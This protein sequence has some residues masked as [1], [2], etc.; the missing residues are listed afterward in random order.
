MRRGSSKTSASGFA[1]I[2]VLLVLL[3]LLVLCA[4]FLLTARNADRASAELSDRVEARLLLD[5]AARHARVGLQT[6]HPALDSTPYFDTEEE[7]E[8]RSRFP[9]GFLQAA[10]PAGQMWQAQA[11]DLSG[12]IDLNSAPPQVFANL[13]G[14]STRLTAPL[15]PNS[16]ELPLSSVN[17]L[18][19]TGYVWIAGEWVRYGKLGESDLQQFLRGVNSVGTDWMGGPKP[20]STHGAGT[21]VLDQRA[22]AAPLWRTMGTDGAYR[23]FEE[24]EQLRDSA[25][26]ALAVAT[27]GAAGAQAYEGRVLAPLFDW[28]SVYVPVRSGSRWQYPVRVLSPVVGGQDGRLRVSSTRWLNPGA[29]VQID[30][31]TTRETALVVEVSGDGMVFLDRILTND[32]LAQRAELRVLSR[33]PVNLNTA[34]REVLRALFNNLQLVG[35][36]ARIN[37]DEAEQLAD[38]V[39][40]SRPLDG[41][42]DFLRRVV[43]PACSIESLPENAPVVPR[44]LE[45]GRGFIDELDALA[46]YTN[47]LNANDSGLAFSTMPFCFRSSDVYELELRA[48]VNAPAGVE[49]FT[50]VRD[51][52]EVVAPQQRLLQLWARQ[53]DFDEERRLSRAAAW[54]MSGPSATSPYDGAAEPPSWIKAN[55]GSYNGGLFLPGTIANSSSAPE[56]LPEKATHTFASREE[57]A[58]IQ[59]WPS[60]VPEVGKRRGRIVHFDTETRDPEGRYLPDEVVSRA[61]DDNQVRWVDSTVSQLSTSGTLSGLMFPA[62]WSLWVKLKNSQDAC[63]FDIG[64]NSNGSDRMA[65]L[66]ERGDLVL[67]VWDGTGDHTG[68]TELEAGE[69]R[70]ALAGSATAPGFPLDIWH[71]ISVDVRGTRPDQ[72]TML[73]NGMSHGVRTPGMSRLVTSITASTTTIAL[74]SVEGFPAQGVAR[75]G[76]ELVEYTLGTGNS[77]NCTPILSGQ[78]AG[79]GGRL[80]RERRIYTNGASVPQ[81]L[82]GG[83]P[84]PN[85]GDHPAGTVVQVFGYSMP[86]RSKAP[87]G[88]ANLPQSLGTFAVGVVRGTQGG[89]PTQG[90]EPLSVVLPQAGSLPLGYGLDGAPSQ[91]TGLILA[92]PDAE[93]TQAQLMASFQPTGGYVLLVQRALGRLIAQPQTPGQPGQ[94][95]DDPVTT[96]NVRIGGA[97]ILWY[98]GVQG[99]VLLI[100]PARRGNTHGF[101]LPGIGRE[102]RAFVFNWNDSFRVQDPSDPNATVPV[103]PDTRLEWDC[104]AIPI[105]LGVPGAATRFLDPTLTAHNQQVIQSQQGVYQSEYAQITRT[106]NEYTEWVRYD[107]IKGD[108]LVRCTDTALRDAFIAATQVNYEDEQEGTIP[109]N[110]PGGATPG[111]GGS[112]PGG[113]GPTPVGML[114][115]SLS[116]STV[117]STQSATAGAYWND[118][119]G[120][121]ES[122]EGP[123][124]RA[125]S[126]A[127]MFRGTMGTFSH[128][129]PASTAVLPVIRVYRRSI[130]A[131]NLPSAAEP[132]A[133]RVGVGDAI[134]FVES[135]PS[136][137]GNPAIVQRAYQPLQT[138]RYQWRQ[139]GPNQ[140][141]AVDPGVATVYTLPGDVDYECMY[142]GLREA[143]PVPYAEDP[144]VNGA[145]SGTLPDIR[146]RQRVTRFPSGERPRLVANVRIGGA[147]AGGTGSAV[148]SAV[149]D[150]IVFGDVL[151]TSAAATVSPNAARGSQAWLSQEFSATTGDLYVAPYAGRTAWDMVFLPLGQEFLNDWPEDAGLVRIGN[152]ILC[153]QARDAVNGRLTIATNGRALLGTQEQPHHA[154]EAAT[155]LEDWTVSVLSSDL[156]AA[157]SELEIKDATDF[158]AQGT[159]LIDNELIHYTLLEG[160]RLSM[161]RASSQPGQKD[162]RGEPLFRGR[163]GTQA[164]AHTAGTPVILFPFRYWDRWAERADAPEL[165]CYEL[166]IDHPS[167]WWESCFFKKED[168]DG[169]RIGVL[170]QSAPEVPWD[171]DPEQDARLVVHWDGERE[172]APH[173][174][175]AQSDRL[176][177]RV[178]VEYTPQA[179]DPLTGLK[180]G[181]RQTPRLTMLGAFYFAPGTVL[182]SLE[183]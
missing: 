58:W 12:R 2:V 48:T 179:F 96:H 123:F 1:L 137:L 36:N 22:F 82:L 40:E 126:S 172:G 112:T 115:T 135:D 149:V 140:M 171:A 121:R 77:L 15:E 163:F 114:A 101:Q 157:G 23:P 76:D 158:P 73:I 97:E 68:T 138:L 49:R 170:R 24:L 159:L 120:V 142:V 99:N 174:I 155:W 70:Y 146:Q 167:A 175:G 38:L 81:V 94:P 30:D 151:T 62:A 107:E 166:V 39:I 8:V 128:A 46:L 180:H 45:G 177:F 105:S 150:E 92:S 50:L 59:L 117:S 154:H 98:S 47:A 41:F 176:A 66:I 64:A 129:H 132:D 141:V 75:I 4:P 162:G 139:Q 178:F 3:A 13:M 53:E 122:S 43:L 83:T 156:S 32:Y 67:R 181:W 169:A 161:P 5:A 61:A 100:D 31:G 63:L 29:T 153:Y 27:E 91:V 20:P 130:T 28:G 106:Q 51:Q 87:S 147:L 148:P 164:A 136:L 79:F 108:Q 21:A 85:I 74:E 145:S 84:P 118:T 160:T 35:K 25:R 7:L 60:R 54:W 134:F 18:D 34:P 14:I 116:A 182:R 88:T 11:N 42:E 127:M 93:T 89:N 103:D 125:V 10:D 52:V 165:A 26:Y 131:N 102:Q 33:V 17:G 95:T 72:I 173:A 57:N 119:V 110:N 104:F 113:G 111:G 144:Y 133:G 168:V 55:W 78:M 183:R 65:L 80:A 69:V 56:D 19:P 152:E 37:K 9:A 16:K 86:L 44:I 109:V 124:S 143:L 71:H 6:S 90:G